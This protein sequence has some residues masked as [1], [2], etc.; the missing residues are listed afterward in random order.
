MG[1]RIS[2]L[3]RMILTKNIEKIKQEEYQGKIWFLLNYN[4][5]ENENKSDSVC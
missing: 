3:S 2:P 1:K 4:F 5:R